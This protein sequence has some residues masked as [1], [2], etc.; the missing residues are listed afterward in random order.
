MSTITRRRLLPAAIVAIAGLSTV[1]TALAAHPHAGARFSGF[2][3]AS[4]I[5]GF[6]APVTFTVASNGST[7][8]NFKYSSFGCFG[9]GGF[10]PG[11]DYYTQPNNITKVGT[12]KLSKSGSFS[13]SG[14]VST[15]SSFGDTTKTTSAV[16]GRFTSAGAATGTVS[17]SQKISG[18]FTSS[19][20]PGVLHFTVKAR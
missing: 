2:T 17:F 1:A 5:N 10:R 11:I 7:L 3:S 14:V 20:G 6:K 18:K 15:V 13:V 4:P 8:Q 9:A 12:V 19:C 16:S